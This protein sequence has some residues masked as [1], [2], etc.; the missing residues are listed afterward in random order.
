MKRFR[1]RMIANALARRNGGGAV[2]ITLPI[3]VGAANVFTVKYNVTGGA[4]WGR[5][6]QGTVSN[7]GNGIATD[8]TGVY[9]N[10][11]NTVN[12]RY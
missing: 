11:N 9:V 10:K 5:A 2:P 3:S 8:S 7:R 4:Q 1:E 6:I 12:P